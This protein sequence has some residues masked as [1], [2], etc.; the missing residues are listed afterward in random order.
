LQIGNFQRG[1]VASPQLY[2]RRNS[3]HH[4]FNRCITIH[5]TSGLLVQDNVCYDHEGHG[6]VSSVCLFLIGCS[7]STAFVRY[8]I[9]DGFEQNNKIIHNIGLVTKETTVAKQ[10]IPTDHS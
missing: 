8:F 7:S 9:E 6:Y 1:N 3:I 4:T 2:L 5:G 10:T